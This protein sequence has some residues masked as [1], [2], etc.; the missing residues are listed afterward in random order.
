MEM[1]T[2]IEAQQESVPHPDRGEVLDDYILVKFTCYKYIGGR[3][4]PDCPIRWDSQIIEGEKQ[5]WVD[6]PGIKNVT[7]PYRSI[8]TRLIADY[9]STTN[10]PEEEHPYIIDKLF[11]VLD[12]AVSPDLPIHVELFDVTLHP[13]YLVPATRESIEGLERVRLDRLGL[14]V[15]ATCSICWLGYYG[16]QEQLVTG[17]PC[18]HYYHEDCIVQWLHINHFCP[19]CRFAMPTQPST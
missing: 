4:S 10:V 6:L 12:V 3:P 11:E 2:I 9:L 13:S 19:M 16:G 1:Y 14:E 7:S 8:C 5:Y 18:S 15:G 17:L